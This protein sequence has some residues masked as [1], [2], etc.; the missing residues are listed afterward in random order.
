MS[1]LVNSCLESLIGLT[2]HD[3]I[4]GEFAFQGSGFVGGVEVMP[5]RLRGT[6][7]FV[8]S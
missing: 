5:A 6:K 7:E 8:S 4:S 1:T 3:E 2:R